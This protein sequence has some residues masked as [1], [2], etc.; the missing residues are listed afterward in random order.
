MSI[1]VNKNV[2]RSAAG[3]ISTD[4]FEMQLTFVVEF[5]DEVEAACPEDFP[6]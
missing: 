3:E 6:S 2:L 4:A 5:E 1:A